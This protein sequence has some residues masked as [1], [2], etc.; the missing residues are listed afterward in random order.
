VSNFVGLPLMF[1]STILIAPEVMPEW[2]RWAA[3]VNPVNWGVVAAREAVEPGTSWS[4]VGVYLALLVG[5]TAVTASFGTLAF[6]AYRRTL[7]ATPARLVF[8][9]RGIREA[10]PSE[11]ERMGE[12][13]RTTLSDE[14]IRTLQTREGQS[15]STSERTAQDEDTDDVDVDTDDADA[16]PADPS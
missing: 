4:T 8:G 3:H 6:R 7:W 14:D 16:D 13:S 15:Q 1:L 2:M 5:V 9:G 11:E 10:P 12:E